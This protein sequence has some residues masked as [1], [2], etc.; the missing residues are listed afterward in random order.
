MTSLIR[1]SPVTDFRRMQR[2]IDRVFENFL[3]EREGNGSETS[4]WAPRVDLVENE[5]MYKILADLPGVTK[6]DLKISYQ[7][8]T[9]VVTGERR[10]ESEESQG[11][12][13]R[14]ERSFGHF[15]RSFTL[16]QQVDPDRIEARFENGVLTVN[17]PKAE[18][19]KPR[20]IQ[21]S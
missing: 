14:V 4:V 18:E 5:N 8:G 10:M 11:D 2:E 20:Q 6:E 15:Y 21:V 1:F 9:L 12:F 16:P 13:V 3:P 17:A 7:D 19:T